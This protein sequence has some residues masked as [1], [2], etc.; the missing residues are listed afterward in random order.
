MATVEW[1]DARLNDAFDRLAAEIEAMR[2]DMKEMRA[3]LKADI[4]SLEARMGT[5]ETNVKAELRVFWPA[6]VAAYVTLM[7]AFIATQV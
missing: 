6:F 5:F 3:E 7:A 4:A 1:T 2:A